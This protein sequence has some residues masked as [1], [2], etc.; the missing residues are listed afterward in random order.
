MSGFSSDVGKFL[1]RDFMFACE[2][3]SHVRS[4]DLFCELQN[5]GSLEIRVLCCFGGQCYISSADLVNL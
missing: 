4:F 1:K 5:P 2:L 3:E